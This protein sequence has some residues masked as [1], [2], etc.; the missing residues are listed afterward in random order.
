[1]DHWFFCKDFF[2]WLVE[3]DFNWVTKA[4]RNTVLYREIE[5]PIWTRKIYLKVSSME[6]LLQELYPKLKVLGNKCFVSIP[7]IF[8]K[9]S[10]KV[11]NK[12]GES[13]T[14][15]RNGQIAL[16]PLQNDGV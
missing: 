10:Y 13:V 14:T 16:T 9:L 15:Y 3:Q 6:E 8:I 4:K 1:M 2:N 11:Y 7:N 5:H 12:K